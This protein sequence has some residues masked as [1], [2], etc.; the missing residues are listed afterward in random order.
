MTPGRLQLAAVAL[1]LLPSL[2]GRAAPPPGLTERQRALHVL[3]RLEFGARPGEVE[4]VLRVGVHAFIEQ[5]LHPDQID[6]RTVERRLEAYP[7]I[8]MSDSEL[9]ETFV[10]PLRDVRARLKAQMSATG[11]AGSA[12]DRREMVRR[13]I[14]RGRRPR[15]VIEEISEARLVRAVDSPRQLNEVLVDFWMN[16]FNVYAGKGLDRVFVASFEKDAIRPHIWGKF[17]DLLM[18]TAQSP[19]MLVYLDNARSVADPVHRPAAFEAAMRRLEWIDPERA[20]RLEKG[21]PKGINENYARELMELHTLGVDGGYTQK[22]VTELARV[23]TGWSIARPAEG[24]GFLFRARMHD[25]GPKTVL[26]HTFPEGGGIEEGAAMIRILARHPATAHHI[27]FELCQRFVADRPPEALVERVARR[28]LST[29]GDLRETVRAV[30][31]SPEFFDPE[32]YRSRV[33]SPFEYVVSAIRAIGGRVDNPRPIAGTLVRMGEG[34]YLCQ[35]PTGYSNRSSDWVNTGALLAR[36][37]FA[38]A[39]AAGGVAGT[40]VDLSALPRPAPSGDS[41]RTIDA[42]AEQIDGEGV[43]PATTAAIER[44]IA[45]ECRTSNCTAAGS[46]ARTLLP[47]TAGLIL[48]SPEFQKK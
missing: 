47:L 14:P 4:R 22:D 13:L 10:E 6:N 5:Q 20:A 25:I 48:G 3:D 45:S 11:D 40:R 26:G 29:G 38:L 19:A 30:V 23:L 9:F 12:V 18:A 43:S 24:G 17:E 16:H 2:P 42:L 35:P 8:R 44:R 31:E 39:L 27:A 1:L 28:F 21:A 7:A 15:R 32:Y 37:N 36:L 33:K 34:L 41:R 46:G